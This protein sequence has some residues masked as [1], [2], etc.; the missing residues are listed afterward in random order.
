MQMKY[1]IGVKQLGLFV[2]QYPFSL[3][4]NPKM[5]RNNDFC[6]L[7]AESLDILR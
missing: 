2:E 6:V 3:T 5:N 4:L 7:C 1:N